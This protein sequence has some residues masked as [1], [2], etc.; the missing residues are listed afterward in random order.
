M[1]KSK[2]PSALCPHASP[3]LVFLL[4]ERIWTWK[5]TEV[6]PQ[7]RLCHLRGVL[8]GLWASVSYF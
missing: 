8:L 6:L 3:L 5:H 2:G 4:E 7:P 1:H